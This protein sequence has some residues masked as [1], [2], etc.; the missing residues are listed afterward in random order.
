MTDSNQ[1]IP[2]LQ[3]LCEFIQ[4]NQLT[5]AKESAERLAAERQTQIESLTRARD[6]QTGLAEERQARIDELTK[7]NATSAQKKSEVAK[8]TRGPKT[9]SRGT[10]TGT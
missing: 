4:G 7:A 6:E 9:R 3:R 2:W 1:N 8:A 5:K 10:P